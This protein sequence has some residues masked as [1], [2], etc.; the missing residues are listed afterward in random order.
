MKGSQ[1]KGS[2]DERVSHVQP[3]L[4]TAHRTGVAGTT[5]RNTCVGSRAWLLLCWRAGNR[6][7]GNAASK[8]F[9]LSQE[10]TPAS[11]SKALAAWLVQRECFLAADSSSGRMPC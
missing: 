9:C 2:R 3:R 6:N 1:S 7:T 4:H 5:T 11:A 10:S 8:P